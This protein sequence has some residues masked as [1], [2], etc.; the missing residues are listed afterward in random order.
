MY[1]HKAFGVHFF[2]FIVA[3]AVMCSGITWASTASKTL[4]D[5]FAGGVA[6]A[7]VRRP[8]HRDH[9]HGDGL[10]GAGRGGQLRG[11]SESV[12]ANVVLTLVELS[13]L[14]LVILLGFYA[15]AAA[16]ATVAG[17]GIRHP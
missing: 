7:G 15:M 11:A 16:T 2:T 12:K 13:G 10:H 14:V 17:R 9:A 6:K 3:F 1:V 4:A 5:N 8:G